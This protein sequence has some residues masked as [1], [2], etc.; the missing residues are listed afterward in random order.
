MMSQLLY[1]SIPVSGA[2]AV[3]LSGH[4]GGGLQDGAVFPLFLGSVLLIPV[5]SLLRNPGHRKLR[6]PW[7]SLTPRLASQQFGENESVGL[8]RHTEV[9]EAGQAEDHVAVGTL[10]VLQTERVHAGV[11]KQGGELAEG[12]EGDALMV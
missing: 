5:L 12:G 9:V 6:A 10:H 8:H 7:V 2:R 11:L 4:D 3:L 1:D